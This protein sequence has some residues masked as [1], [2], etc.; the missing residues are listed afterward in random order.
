MHDKFDV[1]T[2]KRFATE[3]DD[4]PGPQRAAFDLHHR[5]GLP[6]PNAGRHAGTGHLDG[7]TTSLPIEEISD[8]RFRYKTALDPRHL[9]DFNRFSRYCCENIP[10]K[11]EPVKEKS[12]LFCRLYG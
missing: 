9:D 5:D 6:L 7:G 1:F 8:K 11:P 12:L 2:A 10:P 4:I 3:D